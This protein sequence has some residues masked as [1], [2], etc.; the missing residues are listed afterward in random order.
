MA[1]G[2]LTAVVFGI[3][4]LAFGHRGNAGLPM[5]GVGIV[6]FGVATVS[7]KLRRP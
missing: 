1:Y 2:G 6:M 5:V 7:A 4:L 3:A